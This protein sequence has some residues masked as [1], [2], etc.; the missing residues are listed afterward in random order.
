MPGFG[1]AGTVHDMVHATSASERGDLEREG[2][3][4]ALVCVLFAWSVGLAVLAPWALVIGGPAGIGLLGLA[5]PAMAAGLAVLP[6]DRVAR[7]PLRRLRPLPPAVELA[8]LVEG[9][10]IRRGEV[11]SAVEVR[12]VDAAEPNVG[13]FP[14][15]GG[16]LPLMATT[17]AERLL[18]RAELETQV[19]AQLSIARDRWARLATRAAL[20]VRFVPLVGGPEFVL[21]FPVLLARGDGQHAPLGVVLTGSMGFAMMFLAL[22]RAPYLDR[23]R[24]SAADAAA[25]LL[26]SNPPALVSS[27]DKLSHTVGRRM[28]L[29]PTMF[30]DV[31]CAVPDDRNTRT[32]VNGKVRTDDTE[33]GAVLRARAGRVARWMGVPYR[34]DGTVDAMEADWYGQ[35]RPGP[36]PP[37]G[38]PA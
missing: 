18:T 25:A 12:T 33:A 28:S 9:A 10:L 38:A 16:R 23:R 35:H 37:D 13:A 19:F 3:W 1:P 22:V 34:T 27:L 20:V 14:L 29:G 15:P 7:V 31:F 4:D 17:G 26:T 6:L 30:A 24:A 32:T 5:A 21:S 36:P 8:N 11:R 2:R